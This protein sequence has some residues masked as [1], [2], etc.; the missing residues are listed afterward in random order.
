MEKEATFGSCQ[1]TCQQQS[2]SPLSLVASILQP[3]IPDTVV[4][5]KDCSCLLPSS[6]SGLNGQGNFNCLAMEFLGKSLE[7]HVQLPLGLSEHHRVCPQKQESLKLRCGGQF[8]AKTA[9]LVAQQATCML[10]AILFECP[11]RFKEEAKSNSPGDRMCCSGGSPA[12]RIP[13]LQR[14]GDGIGLKGILLCACGSVGIQLHSIFTQA[15][16]A[17]VHLRDGAWHDG[18]NQADHGL[19][20]NSV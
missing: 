2:P 14:S 1:E 9:C 8:T 10:A 6:L 17:H 4:S 16:G 13:S 11:C 5:S 3:V 18:S 12:N 15:A 20:N 7:D 19:M